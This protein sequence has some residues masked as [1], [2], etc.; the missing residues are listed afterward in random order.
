[1]FS[2]MICA[3][4]FLVYAFIPAHVRQISNMMIE[5]FIPVL[6]TDVIYFRAS[7]VVKVFGVF[8]YIIF[9]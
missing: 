3:S 4:T 2:C 8:I 5:H 9:L 6:L 1:M 7:K